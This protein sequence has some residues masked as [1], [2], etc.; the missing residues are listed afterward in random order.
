VAFAFSGAYERFENRKVHI[1]E[2][3]NFI[4][5]AYKRIDLLAPATQPEIRQSFREY[6]DAH[7]AIYKAAASFKLFRKDYFNARDIEDKLWTQT[8]AALKVTNDSSATQLFIPAVN[9]MFETE[10]TGLE[11][12]RVHPP[13]AIFGLLIGL[14][15]L[16]GFLA[17]YSTADS[18]SRISLHILC[19]VAITAFTIYVIIDLEFP[20]VG[21]IR[22]D[23]FDEILILVRDHMHE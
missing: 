9:N 16:S 18:E 3:A 23:N 1:L 8:I 19:Y 13:L 2:E 20:R 22:V 6:V 17:G 14:A 10:N 7:L 11:M 12:T 21:L 4:D 5:T 15:I